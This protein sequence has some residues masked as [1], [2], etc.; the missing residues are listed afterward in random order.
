MLTKADIIKEIQK[1]AKENGGKTPSEKT[2]YENTRVGIW[3]RMRYWPNYG[4]MVREAGLTPNKFD[5]TKYTR[6]QLCEMFIATIREE[7]KWPTRGILDVKH[8]NDT[9]FPHSVTFYSKLGLTSGLAQSILE[10]IEDRKGFD[11]IEDICNSVLK[12]FENRDQTSEKNTEAEHGW[13]YLFKHGQ[14]NHYRIGRTSDLLRR[15]NEIRIQL[16]ER[17][18]LIH[19]IETVDPV[20]IETYWLNRFKDKKLNGDWFKLTSADVKE[21]K[22][23]KKIT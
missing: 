8:F 4:E 10:Y 23:W 22:R 21:F 14:Y 1:H 13:V 17:A 11:D 16:P 15:G 12:K 6:E 5:K 18:K 19:E 3:D 7:G 9:S 20:G 2:L